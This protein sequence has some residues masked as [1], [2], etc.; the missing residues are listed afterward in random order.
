ML[1]LIMARRLHQHISK[2]WRLNMD[3][4]TSNLSNDNNPGVAASGAATGARPLAGGQMSTAFGRTPS[5]LA[6][7]QPAGKAD[8]HPGDDDRGLPGTDDVT[9]GFLGTTN[10]D[11]NTGGD[12]R[13]GRQRDLHPEVDPDTRLGLHPTIDSSDLPPAKSK[14]GFGNR[15]T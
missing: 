4:K 2:Q 10:V 14:D 5:D 8:V 13:H 6:T 12:I 1:R 7:D 11:L 3:S 9:G 15:T